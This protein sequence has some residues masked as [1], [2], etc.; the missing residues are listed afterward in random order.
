MRF[1]KIFL[2]MILP[3]SITSCTTPKVIPT[4]LLMKKVIKTEHKINH[5]IKPK[6]LSLKES[7]K[8]ISAKVGDPI[9]LRIFKKEK[10]LEIWVKVGNEYKLCK[11]Y[12]VCAYSG[13]LGPKLKQ[14]DNQSPE[15]FYTITQ[16]QLKPNSKYHLALNLGFPNQYDKYQNRTGTYLMI[17]GKCSSTGCYAMKNRQI[18]EIYMMADMALKGGQEKFHVHIFPFKMTV[19]NMEKY[20]TNSWYQFWVN[21]KL[22]YDIFERYNIVPIIKASEDRY[23]FFMKKDP[24]TKENI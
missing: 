1:F 17:H 5:K 7:L 10:I 20:N 16:K 8:K 18:E 12:P 22:G 4:K 23:R 9:F 15:G 11:T 13:T 3:F 14:G 2:L 19:K 6:V 21:L 24:K